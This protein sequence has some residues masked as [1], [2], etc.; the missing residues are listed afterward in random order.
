MMRFEKC[1]V[2]GL[3]ACCV[4]AGGTSFA[5]EAK[6]TKAKATPATKSAPAA[7]QGE[8]KVKTDAAHDAAMAEMM[9]Y[10]MPGPSHETLKGMQGSWKAVV[11]S[12]FAPGEPTVTEGTA[13]CRMILGDRF[14]EQ[15]FTGAL[16]GQPF[17]GYGVTGY[18]NRKKEYSSFWVDNM[19]TGMM[20]MTGGTLDA[21]TKEMSF[22][23]TMD[24]PDGTP[25][26]TRTVTKFVSPDN[27]VFSMY[28]SQGGKEALMLEI[29]YT[30]N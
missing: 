7:A 11:K 3:V 4:M 13:D 30:R 21:A 24:G 29:T 15:R 27:H 28:A 1:V 25:V 16:M 6:S 19:S 20:T 5:A 9:K 8:V 10:M 14:L 18:D 12:W 26:P 17:E 22:K 2:A 23:G